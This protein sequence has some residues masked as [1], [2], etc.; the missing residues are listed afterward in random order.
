MNAARDG[1]DRAAGPTALP[2][3]RDPSLPT[4]RLDPGRPCAPPI[5]HSYF[6]LH[7]SARR[8][9]GAARILTTSQPDHVRQARRYST[10]AQ[11]QACRHLVYEVGREG[12]RRLAA[13]SGPALRLPPK[14]RRDYAK[15]RYW[16]RKAANAGYA[17]AQ[18]NLGYLYWH[19]QGGPRNRALGVKWYKRAAAAGDEIARD[20]LEQCR[21]EGYD[22]D[23][24]P[25]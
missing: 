23:S 25:C 9:P 16:Y 8:R 10:A 19:G 12:E 3:Q 2:R 18:C 21:E 22:V 15:A 17:D 6:T 4:V 13:R 5:H 14:V 24:V 11:P 1:R 7:T 20:N